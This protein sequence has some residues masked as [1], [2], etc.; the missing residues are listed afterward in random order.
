M[1]VRN[2]IAFTTAAAVGVAVPAAIFGSVC[3]LTPFSGAAAFTTALCLVGG[4]LSLPTLWGGLLSLLIL[5]VILCLIVYL[6]V[7]MQLAWLP[8]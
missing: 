2:S 5:D 4:L 8:V 3:L 7:Q 6:F 1:I